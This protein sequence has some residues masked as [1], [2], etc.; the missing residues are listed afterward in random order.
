M[1]VDTDEILLAVSGKDVVV[2]SGSSDDPVVPRTAYQSVAA[3]L[4]VGGIVALAAP[5]GVVTG[6]TVE[7]VVA[8]PASHRA[9]SD[10]VASG[11]RGWSCLVV[12][13]V[14]PCCS[15]EASEL[16]PA[17][18]TTRRRTTHSI[19]KATKAMLRPWRTTSPS[20]S[21][22]MHPLL[23]SPP[24]I[25]HNKAWRI[26]TDAYSPECVEKLFGKSGRGAK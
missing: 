24:S 3:G 25:P 26:F 18:P 5:N 23:L 1:R 22:G 2:V 12:A 7:G 11:E 6:T 16:V 9:S 19:R 13:S 8:G 4:A 17:Q 14:C 10:S 21:R 15:F 20:P